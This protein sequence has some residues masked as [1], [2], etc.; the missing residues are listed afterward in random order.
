MLHG[1]RRLAVVGGS[2]AYQR[3]LRDGLDSRV[4][5]RFLLGDDDPGESPP[6][7]VV[8]WDP[9]GRE[10]DLTRLLS[11]GSRRIQVRDRSLAGMLDAV[12]EHLE[13]L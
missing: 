5:C 9:S 12:R 2:P 7:L 13:A 6:R 4:E 10:R 11:A 1:I 3:V 8:D